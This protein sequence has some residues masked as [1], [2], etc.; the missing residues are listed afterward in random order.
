MFSP[1]VYRES[2][3]DL[4][5]AYIRNFR[6]R[7]GDEFEKFTPFRL[8]V[9]KNAAMLVLS[10]QKQRY[11]LFP[12]QKGITGVAL[13]VADQ[14]RKLELPVNEMGEIRVTLLEFERIVEAVQ[15]ECGPGWA[16]QY[17]EDTP[18]KV[19]LELV[20]LLREWEFG[21]ME[22]DSG[23]LVIQSGFAR[24]VGYYSEKFVEEL[25]K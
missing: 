3:D 1:I 16:K 17:R 10:D 20:S 2:K 12:N 22:T 25:T 4:D 18:K 15:L 13:H 6:N 11:T 9:F 8:E 5:F 19:T 21:Y 14:I 7:L 23:I 24:T